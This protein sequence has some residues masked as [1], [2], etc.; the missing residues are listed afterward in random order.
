LTEPASDKIHITPYSPFIN[1]L[2]FI[3]Y[4]IITTSYIAIVFQAVF[5]PV[6]TYLFRIQIRDLRLKQLFYLIPVLLFILIFNSFRGGGEIVF[7]AGPLIVMAQGILRGLFYATFVTELF[8]MSRVLTKSF[9]EEELISMLYSMNDTFHRR[10]S[11]RGDQIT[12]VNEIPG[13]VLILYH[14][15]KIFHNTYAELRVFIKGGTGP[16]REKTLRF[17]RTVFMKSAGDFVMHSK[18]NISKMKPRGLDWL[19]VG[20]QVSFLVSA[21]IIEMLFF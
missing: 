11:K 10:K 1:I 19:H 7:R 9:N 8:F 18:T 17:I 2:I 12:R 14:I 4:I 16:L 21:S 6:T 20:L 13:F 3:P 15:L 5:I